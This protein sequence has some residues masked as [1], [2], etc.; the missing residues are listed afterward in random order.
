M[1]QTVHRISV[2]GAKSHRVYLGLRD[3][4]IS[5]AY[6]PGSKLPGELRLVERYG[7]SR[8]TVRRALAALEEAGMIRRTPGVGT[9]VLDQALSTTRITADAS[10]LLPNIIR[11]GKDSQIRLLAFNYV[12]VAEPVRELLGLPPGARVQRSVRLR[13]IDGKPFSHLTTHVPAAIAQSYSEEDLESTPLYALLERSGVRLDSATQTVSA[14]LATHETAQALEVAEGAP[15]ISLN[16][17]VY[18][19]NGN[20]IEHLAALYRPDRY[21]LQINLTRAGDGDSRYWEHVNAPP[22]DRS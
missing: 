14:T 9:V 19:V 13:L 20:G 17:V 1:T 15:L 11:M 22:A 18:D 7:V 4:I 2:D 5:G 6:P 21:R 16:R 10:N 3:E 8:V 12:P